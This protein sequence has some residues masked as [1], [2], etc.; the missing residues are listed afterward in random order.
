MSD[1]ERPLAPTSNLDA[2]AL[3][4]GL[5]MLPVIAAQLRHEWPRDSVTYLRGAEELEAAFL[6]DVVG[7][8][9]TDE[10]VDRWFGGIESVHEIISSRPRPDGLDETS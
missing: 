1:P 6:V 7:G 2:A 3:G 9:K 8:M 10:I 4:R 5:M